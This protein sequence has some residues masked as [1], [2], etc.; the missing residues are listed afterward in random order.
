[1][2]PPCFPKVVERM[3][4]EAA[5]ARLHTHLGGFHR[6][7]SMSN[8]GDPWHEELKT[9]L[10]KR[11]KKKRTSNLSLVGGLEHF[12]FSHIYGNNHPN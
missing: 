3:P 8:S 1:M 2:K 6:G 10:V 5:T 9:H 11:D 12:L 7:G 4:K